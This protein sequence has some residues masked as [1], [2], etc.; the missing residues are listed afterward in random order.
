MPVPELEA[1]VGHLFVVGGRSISAA[2]PGATAMPP[3]RR[4]ARGRDSDTFF[5]LIGLGA[6]QR[7]SASLYE[8]S[9]RRVAEAYFNT[10]GSV[11]SA[12][13]EAIV[14]ANDALH[15]KNVGRDAPLAIGL[16]CAVLREQELYIA[17][18]GPARCFLVREE[19]VE[20]LPDDD[21]IAEGMPAL[22]IDSEPDV[23]FYRR[24]VRAG[25]F[26]I[27]ADS[28]LNHL[29]S[30]TLKHAVENGQVDSAVINLRSVAGEFA[31]AEV[32]KLVAPLAEGEADPAPPPRRATVP[33]LPDFSAREAAT[34]PLAAAAPP[35]VDD[36]SASELKPEPALQQF[37]RDAA[38]TLARAAGGTRTLLEK[39]MPGEAVDNP[40]AQRLHLSITMQIGVGVAIAVIVALLTTAVYRLRGATSQYAQLVRR[41]QDEIEVAR[42]AG[43]NQAEA[44]PH[45]ETAVF[46]LDQ[47]GE[48]R[49][50][51]ADIWN[52]RNEALAVLDSYDHVTRVSPVLLREYDPGAY[53]HGPV[54]QGI[55]V[56]LIDTT[57]DIL[58][59]EDLAENGTR[60]VNRES[61]IVTRRGEVIGG[62]VVGGLIDLTWMVEGGVPQRNVLAMLS[63]DASG[64]GM[65]IT[66][67]PSWDVTAMVLPSSQAWVDPRGIAIYERDLYI[68]DSGANEIW[69]YPATADSYASEPQ[70]Y[71]TDVE[72]QLGD[73]I[74]MEIDT[75][76]NVYVLHSNGQITKY[77]FGRPQD[78]AFEGLPQ[79][80]TR[81]ASLFLNLSPFD[82]AFFITDPD[83]G[84]LYTM[85]LTGAFLQNYKDTE[86]TIF[87]ALSGAYNVDQP[88]NVYVTAGSRLYVFPRP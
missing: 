34:A 2:S 11:T 29:R 84:R 19:F 69:R 61:Q 37:S 88:A 30:L 7:E 48:F 28:S 40:L 83:N 32:I 21:E 64:M 5:G 1:L 53:L 41:A 82:R 55:N 10:A 14:K 35:S 39:M 72:P 46:L 44:R 67:S 9:I 31:V 58:Y 62:Q 54:V 38:M 66:Y 6:G 33:P 68:L 49:N 59:R 60:L 75:N 85:A 23:R 12:L 51:S 56:Y 50:P 80:I 78:F 47:A 18:A 71:F 3:P 45:W 17:V 13:R 16:A 74:D 24:E 87:D 27:L 25:D 86:D 26:L 70:R 36:A 22:G 4:H 63:R 65:L 81:P 8:E 15:Q 57:G 77:F 52:Q 20:R 76:G 79:P 42:G 43:D 73:A